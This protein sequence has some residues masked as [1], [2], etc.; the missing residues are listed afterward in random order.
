MQ[1]KTSHDSPARRSTTEIKHVSYV[2]RNYK[3]V[4]SAEKWLVDLFK[5]SS[6]VQSS[7]LMIDSVWKIHTDMNY[8]I[9]ES[10][11]VIE[12]FVAFSMK[13]IKF[14]GRDVFSDSIVVVKSS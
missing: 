2:Q 11:S 12:S 4:K 1:T 10:N 5:V 14:L 7:Q 9:A 6:L 8:Q 3:T 13:I